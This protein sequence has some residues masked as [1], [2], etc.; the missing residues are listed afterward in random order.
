MDGSRFDAL[1]RTLHEV[2]SRR[3][4]FAPLLGG[5]QGLLGL[6]ETTAKKKKKK[7]KK[8]LVPSPVPPTPCIA[9]CADK[10]CGAA[11]GCGGVCQ[12]GSCAS[13]ESCISGQ[14][15]GVCDGVAPG[16][17]CP[18][19]NGGFC[20]NWNL[21]CPKG[22]ACDG[23][24]CQ[25]CPEV[26][27]ACQPIPICG[28]SRRFSG[29]FCGCL[30]SVEGVTTCSA[31]Y[32]E[33]FACTTDQECTDHLGYPA[34][35]LDVPCDCGSTGGRICLNEGCEVPVVNGAAGQSQGAGGLKRVSWLRP[36]S[37][38]ASSAAD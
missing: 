7:K 15:V 32:G 29:E 37:S 24:S 34:I 13:G 5:A 16:G 38:A 14:C 33:C 27:D 4:A 35:C 23:A 25:S 11:D 17:R 12:S 2:R 9:S 28:F 6:A 21:C 30:T 19:Y 26:P 18:D 36:A 22:Q 20:C 8:P 1:A 10:A 31:A 3:G